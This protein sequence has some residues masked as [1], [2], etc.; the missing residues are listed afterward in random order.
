MAFHGKEKK[1]YYVFLVHCDVR[2]IHLIHLIS[3]QYVSSSLELREIVL[4]E[5]NDKNVINVNVIDYLNL[6]IQHAHDKQF[7]NWNLN[8]IVLALTILCSNEFPIF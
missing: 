3:P 8:V 5:S 2:F 4:P 1:S 7:K 6:E